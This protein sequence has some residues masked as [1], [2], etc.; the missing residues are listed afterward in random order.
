MKAGAVIVDLAAEGGG[1]CE[2]TIPGETTRVGPVTILAPLNVPSM[3]AEDASRLYAK[4]LANLLGLML[5]DNILTID[6]SDEILS[7]T[8]LT[9]AGK[10]MNASS[11]TPPKA[12]V[13]A[14]EAA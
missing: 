5:H 14:A 3:L 2:A 1:N 11:A 8:V 4:N 9:H 7:A 12:P 13:A 6:L 10:R